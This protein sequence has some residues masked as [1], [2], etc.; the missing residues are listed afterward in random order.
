MGTLQLY[1][2]VERRREH[3]DDRWAVARVVCGVRRPLPPANIGAGGPAPSDAAGA[4]RMSGARHHLC[5]G[6]LAWR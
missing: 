5:R 6:S 3:G 2:C 1:V 4:R